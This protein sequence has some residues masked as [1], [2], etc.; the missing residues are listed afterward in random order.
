MAMAA[1]RFRSLM[2][3][4]LTLVLAGA[5]VLH[6]LGSALGW[7]LL[8]WVGLRQK[9]PLGPVLWGALPAVLLFGWFALAA[10]AAWRRRRVAAWLL[11]VGFT[12][13]A[14]IFAH[15]AVTRNWQF[16]AEDFHAQGP[17]KTFYYV[18]WWWYNR[19]WFDG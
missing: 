12:V 1:A 5:G 4:N 14:A 15:D 10:L 18:T 13:S 19:A 9:W 6:F 16:H 8:V 3:R 2:R 17:Q 11:V 7:A